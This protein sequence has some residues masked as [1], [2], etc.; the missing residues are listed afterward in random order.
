MAY[1]SWRISNALQCY[2]NPYGIYVRVYNPFHGQVYI[3]IFKMLGT[4]CKL[5]GSDKYLRT[6]SS[7]ICDEKNV[8]LQRGNDFAYA[9]A[10]KL[11][12]TWQQDEYSFTYAGVINKV[13][14]TEGLKRHMNRS[15][16]VWSMCMKCMIIRAPQCLDDTVDIQFTVYK[17]KTSNINL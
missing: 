6:S 15:F 9:F 13:F 5:H 4:K 17:Q 10:A 14:N 7:S 12:V 2:T 1:V 16:L 11:S 3:W 8:S